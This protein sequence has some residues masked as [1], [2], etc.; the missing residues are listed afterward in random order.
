MAVQLGVRLLPSS[1]SCGALTNEVLEEAWVGVAHS[2]PHPVWGLWPLT[3]H[4][5]S[6]CSWGGILAEGL[7]SLNRSQ[8]PPP[9]G[10]LP[11]QSGWRGTADP[12]SGTGQGSLFPPLLLLL[13]C[14]VSGREDWTWCGEGTREKAVLFCHCYFHLLFWAAQLLLFY[15]G[16]DIRIREPNVF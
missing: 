4:F 12:A 5:A 11:I 14:V 8:V 16:L 7:I 13:L 10:H 3:A 9:M 2:D 6:L 1:F 15:R